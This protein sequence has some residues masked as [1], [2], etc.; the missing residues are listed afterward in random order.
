MKNFEELKNSPS[1]EVPNIMVVDAASQFMAGFKL[2]EA[3]LEQENGLL[4][5]MLSLGAMALELYLKAFSCDNTQISSLEVVEVNV[6]RASGWHGLVNLLGQVPPQHL[7]K[8]KTKYALYEQDLISSH[9]I[10]ILL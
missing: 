2:L 9:G 4:L 1:P 10:K 3:N 7:Q 6:N 5:P 8:M